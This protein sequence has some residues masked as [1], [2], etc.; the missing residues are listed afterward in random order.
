MAHRT[1]LFVGLIVTAALSAGSLTA[2]IPG[3]PQN[4]KVL[5]TSALANKSLAKALSQDGH[6]LPDSIKTALKSFIQGHRL[7][8]TFVVDLSNE[9]YYLFC[10]HQLEKIGINRQRNPC[11]FAYIKKLRENQKKKTRNTLA[12]PQKS[13]R[14]GKGMATS[15]HTIT[16]LGFRND[17]AACYSTAL[18]STPR[19]SVVSIITLSLFDKSLNQI[20]ATASTQEYGLGYETSLKAEGAAAGLIDRCTAVA[21][22]ACATP[23]S[24]FQLYGYISSTANRPQTIYHDHP[25][26]INGYSDRIVI[27]LGRGNPY[28]CDYNSADYAGSAQ[29]FQVLF[30]IKGSIRYGSEIDSITFDA[31]GNP[32]NASASVSLVRT[33]DGAGG[34]CTLVGSMNF[35]KDSNTFIAGNVLS[36]N[37][38]PVNFGP[39][40][41]R[42]GERVTYTMKITVTLGGTPVT[43]VITNAPNTEQ[44]SNVTVIDSMVLYWGCVAAGTM[45]ETTA[46]KKKPVEKIEILEKVLSN[47]TGT[48]LS[49]SKT[50]IGT[51]EN[52]MVKIKD[53]QGNV[54]MLSETHPVPTDKGVML[55]HQLGSGMSVITRKGNAKLVS[56]ERVKYDGKVW[57]LVLGSRE[58]AP[59][60]T[61]DNRTFFANGILVGDGEMQRT[62][63]RAY[64]R[65]EENVLKNIPS[66]WHADYKN[67]LAR[68]RK[69][70]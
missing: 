63:E 21:L 7:E 20:G 29:G 34:G 15:H 25:N 24:T 50:V 10:M 12:I 18:S 23:D 6:S 67:Y 47:N 61:K 64:N 48:L 16:S 42:V 60:L 11:L 59:S 28:D 27:C 5:D 19:G 26:N 14:V 9:Q 38:N 32:S 66:P 49:V 3:I 40:C 31:N 52:P 57:N 2:A 51:E 17:A 39:P 45:V 70:Q 33:D 53:V 68:S 36:W 65:T 55:A 35:F 56:V 62:Y 37:L 8:E 4:K 43:T 58:E 41:T 69:P 13:V 46:G 54:L 44:G 30:P 22:F 1:L